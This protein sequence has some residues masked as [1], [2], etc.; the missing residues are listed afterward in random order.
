[1]R[2]VNVRL[3]QQQIELLDRTVSELS[4]ASRAELLRQALRDYARE[5]Q[6]GA[7]SSNGNGTEGR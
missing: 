7:A 1:M 2:T 3:N 4:S 5:S 6:A